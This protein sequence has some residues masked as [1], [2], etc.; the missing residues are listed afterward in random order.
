[1][2]LAPLSFFLWAAALSGTPGRKV[3]VFPNRAHA[4]LRRGR[5][6]ESPG[7]DPLVAGSYGSAYTRGLQQY[8]GTEKVVQSVV[9]LKHYFAYSIE[10]Y[11][12]PGS[13]D[14][15]QQGVS[16]QNVDVKISA[17]D[18]AHTFFPGWEQTVGSCPT[19][20][21]ALGVMCSYNAVNGLPCANPAL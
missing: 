5:N 9:T 14:P 19:C 17:Y 1:M 16:R 15:A 7:E 20:G 8:T 2:I 12:Q 13:A 21:H 10:S 18:L 6:V 4:P 11:S 3:F